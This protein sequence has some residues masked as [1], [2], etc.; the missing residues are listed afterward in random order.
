MKIALGLEYDGAAF[1]G[2]QTQ[3]HAR[4]VQACLEEALSKVANHPVTTWC[5][6]R[7]DAGVHAM[8]QVV[9]FETDAMRSMRSW[10]LGTNANLPREV[11]VHW[12]VEV[13]SDFNARFSA[14]AR[15]YRY[16]IHNQPTRLALWSQ[17]ATWELRPLD[18]ERM[19]L[20][21]QALIGEH[22]FSSFRAAGCQARHPVRTLHS[23]S[24]SREESRVVL[25]VEANAFL[26]HM[27]RNLTGALL[28]IGRSERPVEWIG[29]LLAARDRTRA[30]VTAP[31]EGLY[32]IRVQYPG[33]FGIPD[34]D[35]TRF[36][37]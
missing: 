21:A 15:A 34:S 9:H 33:H 36:P 35:S 28:E 13:S 19:H 37:P 24:V 6:G 11:A 32:L 23:I 22:D 27:V 31:P 30:G 29:E 12:A 16:L 20:A 10:V 7:T 18:A 26:Q 14:T 5:A 3:R 17:R 1:S 2:W 4:S 25:E 8:G